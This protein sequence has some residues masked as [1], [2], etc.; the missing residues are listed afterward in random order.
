MWHSFLTD[1]KN[2]N[3][4]TVLVLFFGLSSAHAQVF[5]PDGNHRK[6]TP[7]PGTAVRAGTP[8]RNQDACNDR[9]KTD[10]CRRKKEKL[11]IE[12]RQLFRQFRDNPKSK[13]HQAAQEKSS[14]TDLLLAQSEGGSGEAS[15]LASL[16]I[17]APSRSIL[18][19]YDAPAGVPYAKLGYTYAIM[20]SNV[21]GH[22][23][24]DITLM[25][26]SSYAAGELDNHDASF[27]LGSY[28]DNPLPQAF[29]VDASNTTKP[30]VWFR[31]N[32][33][34]LAWNSAYSFSQVFGLSFYG[35][36]GLDSQPSENNP[37]PGFFDTVSYKDRSLIK[38]Y[39]YNVESGV[40]NSDPDVGWMGITDSTKSETVVNISNSVTGESIP[41]IS[42]SGNFWYFADL[43]L[44]YIG[45]RD[46]YLVLCDILHDVLE[47]DHPPSRYSMLRIEDVAALVNFRNIRRLSDFLSD[48]G[49][50]FTIT[51][52]PFYRDPAGV[53]N[54]GIAQEIYMADSE[55]MLSSLNYAVERGAKI[56]LHGYTHQYREEPNPYSGVTGDDFE[57]WHIPNNA[58]VSE[59]SE[60]WATQ[61]MLSGYYEL[62]E[63]GFMPYTWTTPH[64]QASPN[65]YRAFGTLFESRYERSL[66]YT[67]TS[68]EL[69]RDTNDPARDFAAGQFFPYPISRDFY[70]AK[71]YPENLGN[72][73]YDIREIDPASFID[74]SWEEVYLNAVY[75]GV[76]RDGVASFFFHP[77][78]LERSLGVHGFSDFR[79][80]VNGISD[81][82]YE[83][84]TPDEI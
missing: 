8:D 16:G 68:P 67:S 2:L 44:S 60:A 20:L 33:W 83:W 23:N 52:V 9:E 18:V 37:S 81:L 57:F 27:Y 1:I 14:L 7:T 47:I 54:Q 56:S 13:L 79:N 42:R 38:Y 82:G 66:Y 12:A 61:R 51:A 84:V 25:D 64:Y 69:N 75:A 53:F 71:I 41:Y 21:L 6:L 62:L 40:I 30:L 58:P 63:N 35:L 26:V 4:M 78:W 65:A 24:A 48:R 77:F 28:F 32:I 34:Q 10:P 80:L 15:L 45:P 49:I 43:P 50:P 11:K 55:A 3:L 72:I 76:I 5:Q 59:D 36:R 31:Y 73:E 39:D 17:G 22:F 29:L 74:Y 46:R 19:L 70:G